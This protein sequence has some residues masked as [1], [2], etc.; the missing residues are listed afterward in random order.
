[1]SGFLGS[2]ICVPAFC[3]G[4]CDFHWWLLFLWNAESILCSRCCNM[5]TDAPMSQCDVEWRI[6]SVSIWK[7]DE[8][9]FLY[10][11]HVFRKCLRTSRTSFR[12]LEATTGAAVHTTWMRNIHDDLSSL[13]LR[14]GIYDNMRLEIWC[15]IGLWRHWCLC[16]ALHTCSHACY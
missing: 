8:R 6:K 12:E 1:V 5:D 14:G 16:T 13:D 9:T 4:S 3:W 11:P 10:M 15:K 2:V 7:L